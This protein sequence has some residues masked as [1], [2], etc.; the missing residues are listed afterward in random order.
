MNRFVIVR[1]FHAG[2]IINIVQNQCPKLIWSYE[3][4]PFCRYARGI[5]GFSKG[6]GG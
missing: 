2:T 4:G 5:A 6:T 1:A 3:A